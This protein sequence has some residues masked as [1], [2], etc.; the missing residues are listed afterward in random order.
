MRT[1]TSESDSKQSATRT[2]AQVQPANRTEHQLL[3]LQRSIGNRAVNRLIQAKLRVSQPGD[4]YEQEADRIAE[5]L[6][7]MS[8]PV[9]VPA[10]TDSLPTLHRKCDA[11]ASGGGTCSECA[12]QDS[13]AQRKELHSAGPLIQRQPNACQIPGAGEEE[14]VSSQPAAEEP[15]QSVEEQESVQR[16]EEHADSEA[17]HIQR[18]PD[19]QLFASSDV[20]QS[21]E[22]TK[23]LGQSLPDN[24]QREF[25]HKMGAD[26]S[27]VRIHTDS[28]AARLATDL[29][30]HAFT[31][32]TD[33]YFNNGKYSP[34]TS[35]GKFL[36]A[37]ELAHT[38]QQS[39][40]LVRRITVSGVGTGTRGTCGARA[41]D[42]K[43][44]LD[45]AAPS[46]GYMVQQVDM[47]EGEWA[48]PNI[49]M[50]LANPTS[51][52]WEAWR[53]NKGDTLFAQFSSFGLSDMSR[54][55]SV[56]NK[57]GEAGAA[58][59]L[60]FFSKAT[61]GDLGDL[62]TS[63]ASTSPNAGV[64]G[65]GK[66]PRSHLLPSTKSEPSWWSGTAI[67][68]PARRSI[69]SDWRCCPTGTNYNVV[70]WNP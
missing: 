62:G 17:A 2:S 55:G 38:M 23:G 30:A 66:D 39:E 61:T 52:F 49:G 18:S 60:K 8:G 26:F 42:W 67:E 70:T 7:S 34:D 11:C 59:T 5:Q 57:A 12:A 41:R 69:F 13:L 37:H 14:E 40:G 20:T 1:K 21:I 46:E 15:I 31:H 25:G 36:L 47:Y 56:N 64:W 51:T 63:P 48:C 50:C 28:H 4:P 3:R 65:P 35:E 44:E 22:S 19:G 68:G 24:I 54:R 29:A 27:Q 16:L 53:F 6:V 58:G 10:A 45:A 33:I 9:H 43:F 32:G